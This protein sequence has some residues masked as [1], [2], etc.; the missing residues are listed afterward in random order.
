MIAS[1]VD[2]TF[3][4]LLELTADGKKFEQE[5]NNLLAHEVAVGFIRGT[6]PYKDGVDLVDV[7]MF[8]EYGTSTIP[9]RPF[10]EQGLETHHREVQEAIDRA[11]YIVDKGGEAEKGLNIIG[12][13]ARGAVQD[14]IANG[15]FVPN[16][17]STIKKKG[18]SR[19]LIDTGHMRQSVKYYIRKAGETETK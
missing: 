18:S 2:L 14:E 15:S 7:A 19:P 8:N 4:G 5:L 6:D 3:D 12:N 9:P 16:A 11:F 17:P 1:K 13:V 10:L